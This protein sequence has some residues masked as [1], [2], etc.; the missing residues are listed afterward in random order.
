[1]EIVFIFLESSH[2]TSV[3]RPSSS[4]FISGLSSLLCSCKNCIPPL[5]WVLCAVVSRSVMSD[6]LRP[7]GLQPATLFCPWGFSRQEYWSRFPCPPAGD[8]PNPGDQTQVSHNDSLR[9]HEPQHV[10][11]SCPSQTP[12]VYPNPCPLSQ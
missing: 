3:S 12:G 4:C 1:M 6:S 7:H 8:L 5:R 10:R 2:V 9:P 11:P